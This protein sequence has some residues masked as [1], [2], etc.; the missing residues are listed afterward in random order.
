MH[1]E[2]NVCDNLIGTLLD[3]SLK[4]KDDLNARL[5]LVDIGIRPEL[6][7]TVDDKGKQILPPASFTMSREKK[8]ILCSV[9][10]NIKTPDGY[11]SNISRCVNMKDCTLNGLK[12][13]ACH[14]LLEDI[15]PIALRLCYP[16]KAVMHIVI[17]LVRF[18]KK[19]CS[20]VIDVSEL[21]ELQQSIVMTLCDMERVF[22]PSFFTVM[23]HLLVHMVEEVKLGGP[24]HYRWM[25]PLERYLYIV[26]LYYINY[27]MDMTYFFNYI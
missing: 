3:I 23:V 22:L 5:D 14:V 26:L 6:H 10:Q 9:I 13:H 4:T 21:A 12:S 8:E 20:K 2:K 25:Y 17:G 7:P 1:I 19:L 15:L 27:T 11:A 24:V 18:F 16:S